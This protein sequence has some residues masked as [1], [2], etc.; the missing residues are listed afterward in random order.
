LRAT[1][2]EGRAFD[3]QIDAAAQE[4]LE[5]D[6]DVFLA[7]SDA[8]SNADAKERRAAAYRKKTQLEHQQ[9]KARSHAVTLAQNAVANVDAP[10]LA[11]IKDGN[12]TSDILK[13]IESTST[14]NRHRELAARLLAFGVNPK[15]A[16]YDG[17][18][19]RILE[20]GRP[21][22]LGSFD[23]SDTLRLSPMAALHGEERIGEE[24]I[25]LHE[26]VH[27]ATMLAISRKG[28]AAQALR[29]LYEEAR[30]NGGAHDLYGM[31]NLDEFIA[32]AFSSPEF[33]DRLKAMPSSIID[34]QTKGTAI[35]SMFGRLMD[36]VKKFLGIKTE[37]EHT[38]L[39]DVM[40]IGR[41]VMEEDAGLRQAGVRGMPG[42]A[43]EAK[44]MANASAKDEGVAAFG[45]RQRNQAG[46]PSDRAVMDM[47][48]EG[49]TAK[50]VLALIAGTS[51]KPFNKQ[52]A[53][54]LLKT[55]INPALDMGEDMGGGDG[56]TF[57][58]KYSRKND[59]VTLTE[60]AA[61]RAEQILLHELTHAATL[62]A[63]DRKGAASIQMRHLYEHVKKQGGAVGQYG[64]KNVGEFVAEA[65]TNPEFQ[66]ALKS[67]KAPKQSKLATAWDSLVQILKGILGI[68]HDST[69]ALSAAL[70][71]GT[72]V[73]R[74]NRTIKSA[75]NNNGNFDPDDADIAHFGAADLRGLKDSALDQLNKT[76]IHPGKVSLWDKTVGTMRHLAERNAAFKPVFESAQRHIDDVST[77]AND[78]ADAAPRILPRVDKFSDLKFWGADGKKPLSAADN[79]AIGKALFE[80]TLLW[81]RDVD[82]SAVLVDAMQKKY[83]NLPANDKAN[84]MLE[85]GRLDAGV[86]R[87]WRGLPLAQF[88][89]LINSRFDS[90]VL[91]AGVVWS[92]KELQGMMGLNE[93]QI[94]LYREGRAAVDRSIDVTTR[95][96]MLRLLGEERAGMRDMVLAQESL[97]DAMELLTKTLVEEAKANPDMS[98]RLMQIHNQVVDR[99]TQARDLMDAGYMPLSRFGQYTVDVV[100]AAGERQ[101]F[102]MFESQRDSN[103]MRL[104]MQSAFPGAKVVQGTM[105]Q[106]AFK[107]FQG[108][109]P[110][111]LELFG[112]MLGLDSSGNDAKDKAFQE[113][114]K[115]AKNNHS[116]LKRLIHRQGIAGYSEDVGRVLAGF[117][118]SNARQ[119][120][121]ALNAGTMEK[122]I[123]DIPKEQGEL[124]DVAL[125]LRSYISDPQEEGQAVRGML[126]AQYLGGSVASAFVNMTQPFAVTMPWLSQFGGMKKAGQLLG[127]ALKD[128]GT[129]GFQYE[130]SL[131][132]ALKLAE[133]DGTVSPQEIHQLMA[134][135]RGSGSL[136][137]G[138]GTRAGDARAGAANA[139]VR[140][141]VAWGQ[142]FALAEQFNRRS[143]FI[144]AYR[145]AQANGTADPAEFA[146]KAVLETQFL[147]SKANKMKWARGTV[148]GTLMTFK[149]YS[150]SY[151]ELMQRTW[152]A[153]APGSPERAAGRRAVGWAMLMLMLMG[154]AGGLPFM[155]DLEDVIDALAQTM[156]YNVSSKQWRK[157]A[158]AD[159]MGK[160]L[161]DFMDNGLSGLPG[162]PIDVSGRL[163]MGNLIP[164]TGLF[165]T[166]PSRTRDMLELVGPAGD[167]VSRA[168]SGAGSV[169][170]GVVNL[171]AGGAGR[172]VMEMM[173]AAV[174]NAA[175]GTDMAVS[176][177]YKDSKGYKVI[178]T[179]L[180][181]ALAKFMGFQPKSVADDSEATGFKKRSESFY[182]QTSSEIR[183]Q[184]A[185]AL[186]RKDDAALEK[187]RGRLDDWNRNNPDQRITIKM[188]D[189]WK[190]VREMGKDR[191][192]RIAD[193]APKALRG[194]MREMAQDSHPV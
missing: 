46:T 55:G 150:I 65:F 160:E 176:G 97:Q 123:N 81:G 60:G 120:A 18:Q 107:L 112:N 16:V 126:F 47:V 153:G 111:S 128:M 142:P 72:A 146:R 185:D 167:L 148:G 52:L 119:G 61:D 41:M 177:M 181:E 108:V 110:E 32:E 24:R 84:M 23:L 22:A 192:Q 171:D 66:R 129:R 63:L 135:A 17:Y 104:K 87:M 147:Y 122:A 118:Y 100:D 64:M 131:A 137:S 138:D 86:L 6:V 165:Q 99:A 31:K 25:F 193:T 39:T 130:A 68:P 93:Q 180:D 11:M 82:G 83:A 95:T 159:V 89:S 15:T 101:Y 156:G 76:L 94:S 92:D 90:K 12:G 74:E 163:G 13:K 194:Q 38:L 33:Q 36:I 30:Q 152:N 69:N 136:R 19:D 56:F 75:T 98:D 67:M 40:D 96:D 179:T 140:T 70:E 88:E 79:K 7:E 78:A 144:A 173:P 151:L 134:Q 35:Q 172:G 58:A 28:G 186:F 45:T 51:R 53:R 26:A 145:M 54:L 164:G 121:G 161:A 132:H 80:G 116:S 191:T 77:L 124:K 154:G 10:I 14:D 5:A 43:D 166:K 8:G 102:G 1:L 184:W 57:L 157:Q 114:L 21:G 143:T 37:A 113:Y 187:V 105:S 127:G 34:A 183:A 49:K 125:G 9:A 3:L 182:T 174:R 169:L 158:M 109:T 139:W 190:K 4:A 141:K 20:W 115:L 91:K 155:E 162:A 44:S 178:D 71:I 50:D 170:K 59:A 29:D 85:A 2:N 117:V 48:R 103:L 73:M 27:A 175:K 62:K 189:V 42:M 168:F 106:Q 188:P 133:E 149:T